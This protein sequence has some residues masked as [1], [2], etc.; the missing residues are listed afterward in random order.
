MCEDAQNVYFYVDTAKPL[1][2]VADHAWMTLF[3]NVKQEQAGYDFCVNRLSPNDGKAVIEKVTQN[4]YETLGQAD[5]RFADNRLM[6][7]VPKAL[8]GVDGKASFMFKWADNYEDG[9]LLSF[10]TTGDSAPYGR[11]NWVCK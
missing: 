5:I 1:S 10:Y 4:G 7:Q 11:L 9:N 2:P 3:L 6:L 8:L